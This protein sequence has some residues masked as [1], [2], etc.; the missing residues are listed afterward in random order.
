[1][2]KTPCMNWYDENALSTNSFQTRH[3]KSLR[4]PRCT[5]AWEL[6]WARLFAGIDY[7]GGGVSGWTK[8]A[9]IWT[10]NLQN[11]IKML[12]K[13]NESSEHSAN[14]WR[15]LMNSRTVSEIP[16]KFHQNQNEISENYKFQ[17]SNKKF[18]EFAKNAKF[19][20]KKKQCKELILTKKKL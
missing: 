8:H 16:R 18:L 6:S 9:S 14:L 7:E 17:V 15:I 12:S 4:R 19:W 13:F 10:K 3:T 2:L 11:L 5:A 20:K 1:M